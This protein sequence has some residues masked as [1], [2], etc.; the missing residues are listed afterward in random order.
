[1]MAHRSAS[2]AAEVVEP[3]PSGAEQAEVP[4]L[5]RACAA[6]RPRSTTIEDLPNYCRSLLRIE[7]PVVVTLAEKKQALRQIMELGPGSIIQFDKSCNEMLELG[8]GGRSV[9][10]GEAVKVGDQ[11]GLRIRSIALPGERFVPVK[12][13]RRDAA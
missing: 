10:M 11:F 3:S 13:S 4:P 8:V 12:G 6:R 7:V 2:A 9:A 1:M 5:V